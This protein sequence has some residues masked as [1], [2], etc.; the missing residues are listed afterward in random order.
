MIDITERKKTEAWRVSEK[1]FRTLFEEAMDAIFVADAETGMLIDCNRAATKLVGRSKSELIGKHQ[2]ILHPP[3]EIIEK[4]ISKT[5]KQH[6]EEKEGQ[7]LETQIITKTGEIKEVAIKASLIEFGDRKVLQGIFRDITEAK[8]AEATSR[9][10][11]E[12]ARN[13]LEFQN[14]VIDTAIVWI[15][16]LDREGNVTLW[17]RAAEL[18]SGYTREEVT[19]H[20]RI[21]DWLYPNP[22]Y[23]TEVFAR[24]KRIIDE[25]LGLNFETEIRC[26]DGASKTIS[27]YTNSITDGKGNPVGSIAVGLDVSQLKKAEREL[28]GAMEKLQVLNEKLRVVGGLTRHDVRNKLAAV[29]GNAYLAGKKLP[30]NSEVLDYLKQIEASV[31]E[32]V[33]IL[34]FAR[35]YEM[36]GAEELT[37]IAVEKAVDEAIALFADFNGMKVIN[38]CHGLTVLADSLLRQLFYNLIDNSL[39]YG[40]KTTRIR[41]NYGKAGHGKLKLIYEDDGVGISAADKSKLFKEGYST[42]GST[43]YGLHLIR[44][45]VEVYG[46]TIEE[47]GESGKG[48]QF[49]ITI[50]KTNQNGR[51]NYQIA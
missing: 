34:D 41:L 50:S 32:A 29:T 43:G 38:N 47:T 24:A 19:G 5:F 18:I 35:T 11:S 1:R 16:L 20:R 33:R 49:T 15:D 40:K 21:W 10:S 36:L 42:G 28:H 31:E 6:L 44:K 23:C 26:K 3:Q 39:K 8:Q 4:G 48:A 22:Q 51:E 2:R 13:L 30:G 14:K 25:E 17:N 27:W 7:I 45:I 9:K 37:Y 12:Q 46:W